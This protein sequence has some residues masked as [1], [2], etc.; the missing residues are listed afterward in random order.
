MYLLC[1]S[2]RQDIALGGRE[3]S[4]VRTHLKIDFMKDV[5]FLCV[6][7]EKKIVGGHFGYSL[8]CPSELVTS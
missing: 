4:D 8:L 2:E 6:R 1:T 3:R 5:F 7:V